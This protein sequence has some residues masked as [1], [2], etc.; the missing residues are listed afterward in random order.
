MQRRC[1]LVALAL[2]SACSRPVPANPALWE[3]SGPNAE[4]GWLFGTIHALPQP[5]DWRT[6]KVGAA[7][8]AA[9]TLVLEIARINDD[10][11][12]AAV[13]KR[14][15]STPGQPPLSARIDP[16]LRPKLQALMA[17]N[18]LTDKDFSGTETW[19]A[20]LTLAQL[21]APPANTAN[22]VDR[23]LVQAEPGKRL[24]ELEGAE[25]QL[26]I[27][28]QLPEKE[29]QDLL[30]AAIRGD[31]EGAGEDRIAAA[32]LK[33]DMATIERATHEGLLADPELREALYAGRNRDWAGQIEATLK[34]GRH[35]FVAVGAAHLAGPDGVPAL[36]AARGW[37]VRRAE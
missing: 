14:L 22:G 36:L 18:H 1:I 23:A 25:K 20:A 19:A 8:D 32:W 11:A 31:A 12:T 30:A 10:A 29:Q 5:A 3:V 13:F 28:D 26:S 35:P 15:A 24:A 17:A 7:L 16:A 34:S 6:P 9:D 2:L 37:T 33:G 21:A 4:K 27:F